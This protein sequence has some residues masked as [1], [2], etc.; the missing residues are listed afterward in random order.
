MTGPVIFGAN[1]GSL[2]G[3]GEAGP[4]AIA[5]ISTLKSYIEEAL[6]AALDQRG[7]VDYDRIESIC[8]VIISGCSPTIQV[9]DR[10]L[11][12]VIREVL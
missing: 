7:G 1:G 10:E 12:R 5:P 3:G 2:M 11:G 4:E 8:K 6:G 9:G